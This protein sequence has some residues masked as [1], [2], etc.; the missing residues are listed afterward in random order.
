M[1]YLKEND[2]DKM[3]AAKVLV[4][5]GAELGMDIE[6]SLD[7]GKLDAGD[8]V[9]FFPVLT[10]IGDVV[11]A[12]KVAPKSFS[13]FT[14]EEKAELSAYLDSEL[15]LVNDNLEHLIEKSLVVVAGIM[16]LVHLAGTLKK[17]AAP[18]A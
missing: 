5:F 15:D 1:I 12:I 13:E 11:E 14:T 6:K 4:K 9:R 2:M 17:V 7:D 18:V 3:Q 10:Q 8:A 16:E